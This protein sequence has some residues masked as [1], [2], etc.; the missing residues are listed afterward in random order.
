M[1][2]I[3][4]KNKVK[5]VKK[6]EIEKAFDR[7]LE[8]LSTDKYLNGLSKE[9]INGILSNKSMPDETKLYAIFASGYSTCLLYE[10]GK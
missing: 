8:L 1:K 4:T 3:G 7:V 5:L 9:V 10:K 6:E 2:K